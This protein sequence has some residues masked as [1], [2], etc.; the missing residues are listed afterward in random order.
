MD[1]RARLWLLLIVLGA[2]AAGLALVAS[3]PYPG[4]SVDSGEYLAV[5]DGLLDGKGLTMPYA[6]YDEA[7]RILSPGE[8]VPMTQFPPLYPS[9]LAL[10][11]GI[12]DASLLVVA[13]AI[14]A[15]MYAVLVATGTYLVWRATRRLWP[16]VV[17]GGLLLAADLV[18]IHAMA[19]SEQLMLLGL[20]GCLVF[21]TR[22][23]EGRALVDVV[24]LGACAV[25]ASMAR[26]AGVST[27]IAGALVV[28][29]ARSGT[30][31]TR[32]SRAGSFLGLTLVPTIAWFVR[33]SLV[34]GAVSDKEPAW[35]PPSLTV[36]GQAVQ[37]IGGW[38]V[39]WRA[40]TMAT[41]VAVVAA[42]VAATVRRAR[43]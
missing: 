32:L 27:A 34:T 8:R 10:V 39:P 42:V 35:H 26:F 14:G 5:A 16:A 23:W 19:W 11:A 41:G 3:S 38:I 18:T 2:A 36:L 4:V 30:A 6:G 22:Y 12:A 40:A 9:V 17:A 20:C 37:T 1:T 24:G 43:S 21:A 7:Y 25:V 28:W 33:N 15:L 13:R 29:L 31:R